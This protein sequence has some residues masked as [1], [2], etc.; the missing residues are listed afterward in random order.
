M[1]KPL[2][3][4]FHTTKLLIASL[5]FLATG[6]S[7]EAVSPPLPMPL[8]SVSSESRP[9]PVNIKSFAVWKQEKI[10]QAQFQLHQ[11][12]LHL[13]ATRKLAKNPSELQEAS[14]EVTQSEWEAEMAS[15][16]TVT[17]YAVLYLSTVNAPAKLK[18]AA[19]KLTPED[20]FRLLEAYLQVL[21]TQRDLDAHALD[22]RLPRHSR[23]D[24]D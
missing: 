12:R 22:T 5:L 6:W 1:P 18:E 20:T 15:D 24:D 4:R 9:G 2:H 16:L 13:E 17:D 11:A 19:A 7:A 23:S 10:V 8:S 3:Q 21:K 14:R